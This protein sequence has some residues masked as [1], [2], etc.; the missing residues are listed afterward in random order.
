MSEIRDCVGQQVGNYRLIELLGRGGFADV[1]LGEHIYLKTQ[2]AI[3][4]LRVQLSEAV[5]EDFL[6]EARTIARMEHPHIVRVFECG[7][8]DHMPFLVMNY[9]PNGSL[10]QWYP[11]GSRLTLEQTLCYVQQVASALQYAHQQKLI[12]RDVKPENML[13]GQN[14]QVLLSDFGLV[15]IAQSS[16]SL[17]TQEMAGTLPYMAPE[18]VQGKPRFAS[19]QYALGIVAYEWLSGERPFNGT[20]IEVASQHVLTPPPSLCEKVPTL[21]IAVEQVIFR[22]LAKDPAERFESVQAFAIAL[23]EAGARASGSFLIPL[24]EDPSVI[25]PLPHSQ[26]FLS[27]HSQAHIAMERGSARPG[28]PVLI[29]ML[30]DSLPASLSGIFSRVPGSRTVVE[31]TTHSPVEELRTPT[32]ALDEVKLNVVA[33]SSSTRALQHRRNSWRIAALFAI[34]FV[35]IVGSVGL[36]F[37]R[38]PSPA[39]ATSLNTPTTTSKKHVAGTASVP[40]GSGTPANAGVPDADLAT[41]TTDSGTV[42]ATSSATLSSTPVSQP[43][44]E[45]TATLGITPTEGPAP[46]PA[47]PTAV[48]PTPTPLPPTPTPAPP[49]RVPPTPT[50]VPPTPASTP[51]AAMT[52]TPTSSSTPTK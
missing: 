51:A 4:V 40:G 29:A 15:M 11:R 52:P 16:S 19:D 17:S 13:I 10:R 33:L 3:K 48:P 23:V 30:P 26:S 28:E 43:T 27:S 38:V 25:F 21:P 5:M 20:F 50:P 42:T 1:Y 32:Q 9:A 49:T 22:A 18:Q 14:E 45:V 7:L 39:A 6:N 2:A 24:S 8:T 36:W 46:S 31:T 44:S 37:A 12:H 35:L 41:S 47:V 34:M